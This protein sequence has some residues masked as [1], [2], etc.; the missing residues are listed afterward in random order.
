MAATAGQKTNVNTVLTTLA[1]IRSSVSLADQD[2]RDLLG[3]CKRIEREIAL[4]QLNI[5]GGV[6]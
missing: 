4:S 6:K 5:K 2:Q 1:T 3:L